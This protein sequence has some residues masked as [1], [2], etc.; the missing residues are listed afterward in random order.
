MA[1]EKNLSI[2]LLKFI[3]VIAV[4]NSHFDPIYGKYSFLATG[5]AIGDVLFFFVSGFTI[6]LGRFGRFDNWFKRRIK[7]IYPSLI[8]WTAVLSFT[9]IERIT[10][11]QLF[12]GGGY[13]FI[14][15]IMLYYIV[16]YFVR[17]Y[18]SDKPFI[19]FLI[20]IGAVVVWYL[21]ENSSVS[22][23][24]GDTYFKWMHYFLFML[25]GA[26]VGNNTIKLQSKPKSDT[27]LLF[28]SIILFYGVFIFSNKNETVAHLQILSLIPLLGIVIYSF[29][30]CCAKCVEG[31]MKRR[32]GMCLRFIG[33]L[34]LESYIVQWVIIT[35][36]ILSTYLMP[37]FPS[38]IVITFFIII[39]TAYII[40]CLG[41][42]VSQIF[43][44]EDFD[45]KAV[46]ELVS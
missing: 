32:V 23:M 43:E 40:R 20:C 35:D 39:V 26:Y 37:I 10:V 1:R 13:W 3:A 34:C 29:K 44:K 22:F 21:F 18:A 27:L 19:P 36:P 7:R 30:L 42:I 16:L 24:Y 41:R 33:S 25:A 45:W 2:E 31:I 8:A 12:C 5:G 9:G 4:L 28:I 6:F 11:S 15:C 38:N 46:V 17:K 14:S